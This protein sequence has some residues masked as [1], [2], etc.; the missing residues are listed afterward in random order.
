MSVV[1]AVTIGGIVRGFFVRIAIVVA[2]AV[3]FIVVFGTITDISIGMD[4]AVL[5]LRSIGTTTITAGEEQD[6]ECEK[7]EYEFHLR[8]LGWLG[9]CIPQY[10][11]E[12]TYCLF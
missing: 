9:G 11:R 4:G 8:S 12:I 3:L 6:G 7:C 10:V 2:V 1:V 5:M